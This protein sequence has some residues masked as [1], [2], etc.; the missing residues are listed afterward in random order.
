MAT[1]P[2][3]S[4]H[5]LQPVARYRFMAIAFHWAMFVLVVVVCVLGLLHLSIPHNAWYLATV[6]HCVESAGHKFH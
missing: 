4:S 6:E 5:P 1:N 3:E 2:L